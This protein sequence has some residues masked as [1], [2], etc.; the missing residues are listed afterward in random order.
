MV[1]GTKD[2]ASLRGG[3]YAFGAVRAAIIEASKNGGVFLEL[4]GATRSVALEL[5]RTPVLDNATSVVVVRIDGA[6]RYGTTKLGDTAAL[7]AAG[8]RDAGSQTVA[9]LRVADD[10]SV[11]QIMAATDALKRAGVEHVVLGLVPATV[12]PPR[13]GWES[14]P[15]PTAADAVDGG[16][17]T[18]SVDWDDEGRP[19][20]VRVLESPGHGFGG[21]ATLCALGQRN[22]STSRCS[23][24]LP[25]S[26]KVNV[27]FKRSP[28]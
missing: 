21:A 26:Q 13:D 20:A 1:A 14:C 17:V 22:T 10:V 6:V 23:G 12:V 4:Q 11:E 19:G 25:C 27:A 15:F 2:R 9:L 18:L 24:S 5:P 7:E 16:V 3:A 8:R 28:Q